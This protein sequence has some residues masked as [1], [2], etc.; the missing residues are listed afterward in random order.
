MAMTRE[1]EPITRA[2]S[3]KIN[4]LDTPPAVRDGT[5]QGDTLLTQ[6]WKHGALHDYLPGLKFKA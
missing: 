2:A 5:L 4:I 3:E 6:R 1:S